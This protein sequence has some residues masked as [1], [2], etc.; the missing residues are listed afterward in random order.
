MTFVD[1][2]G[3]ELDRELGSADR[4][5]LFTTARR[6]AAVNAAQLEWVKRTECLQKQT[7]V[8]LVSGTQEYDIESTVTDFG[9]IARQGVSIAIVRGSTTRYIEGD[10]LRVITVDRLN[11][12]EPGWRAVAAGTPR[13]VYVRRDGGTVNLG[14]HPKPSI[15]VGDTWTALLP[16]VLVPAD[17]SGDTDEPFTVSSN[18]VKSLRFWHRALVY[19]AAFDAEKYRKDQGRE[20]A[21][22]QLFEGEI[23]KFM[24]FEKPRGG[25][26]VR[27]ARNYRARPVGSG[28]S[29]PRY[30]NPR[31]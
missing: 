9:F 4:T 7:T 25:Q 15:T 13:M 29:A 14:F 6:K 28:L 17:M 5:Q 10:D 21:M 20:Q 18:P 8:S 24:N 2:Y 26:A 30:W 12:E 1:L 3:T 22:L 27:L 16:Y 11:V 19:F 23:Q 31:T